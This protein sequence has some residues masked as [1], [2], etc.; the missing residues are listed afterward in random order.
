M[1]DAKQ[2]RQL[3]AELPAN[4]AAK[5]LAEITE[6]VESM[7]H[8]EGFKVDRRFEN[9][10][11]LD[12]AAK[13]H[14]RKLSQDYLVTPRQQKFQ[15][16]KLF[17]S[18]SG[19]WRA[20]GDGYILCIDQHESGSAVR[21]NLPVVVGR[22]LRVLTLQLKWLLLRYGPVEPHLWQELARL[23]KFA[24]QKGYADGKVAVYPGAHGESTL[25]IE[26][27]KSLMLAASSTDGLPPL[28]QQLA[29]RAVAQFADSFV[30]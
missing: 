23:Y 19:F 2:A 17:T 5:A 27:L 14:Q 18:V 6:W 13:N 1:A 15:E 8:T 28:K 7:N 21:K 4:D 10:D 26:F 11:L 29:E 9:L 12:G 22:A 20:L 16:N 25:R 24:E 3:V 30:L